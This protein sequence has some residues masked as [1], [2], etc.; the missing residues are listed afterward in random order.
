MLFLTDWLH[1]K[2][3]ES[4]MRFLTLTFKLLGYLS[5]FI[6]GAL[7]YYM[8]DQENYRGMIFPAIYIFIELKKI[9]SEVADSSGKKTEP[10]I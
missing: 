6:M 10:G 5:P 2:L 1:S 7:L 3:P 9:I 8:W 4:L